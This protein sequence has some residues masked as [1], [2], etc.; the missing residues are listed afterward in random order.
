MF[1]WVIVLEVISELATRSHVNVLKKI[2]CDFFCFVLFFVLSFLFVF[3]AIATT[4]IFVMT[5]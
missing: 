5:N 4:I 2:F 3:V 1:T